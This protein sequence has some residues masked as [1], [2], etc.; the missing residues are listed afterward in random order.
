[1]RHLPISRD[2][3][4][5]VYRHVFSSKPKR[6]CSV[7]QLSIVL[8][9]SLAFAQ[10]ALGLSRTNLDL[11]YIHH[12]NPYALGC[13][14]PNYKTE[15]IPEVRVTGGGFEPP[16]R[17]DREVGIPLKTYNSVHRL[18]GILAPKQTSPWEDQPELRL[19]AAS[20]DLATV[21]GPV[22]MF[23]PIMVDS[24]LSQPDAYYHTRWY[25]HPLSYLD[26]V[27]GTLLPIGPPH[28]SLVTRSD[29][30][31]RAPVRRK[32][33]DGSA[34]DASPLEVTRG[35]VPWYTHFWGYRLGLV[36][37]ESNFNDANRGK[38]A[39][40]WPAFPSPANNFELAFLPPPWIEDDVV[41]Y[42]NQKDFPKQPDGQ[43]FYAVL[44]A[45]KA[46][47]DA[48]AS[49]RRTGKSFKSGGYVSVCRFYG[50]LNGGPN[51]HFYSADDKEC[52]ALKKVPVLSYEGQT[53]AVNM[54][55]PA[56]TASQALPG[57]L[58]DCPAKSKP[59]YRLY[60]N[61]SAPGK[62]YVSNH[63]YVT[64]RADVNAAV[65]QGWVDEG[66]VMCVPE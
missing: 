43:F 48:V 13:C 14:Y 25:A 3:V 47:L 51:T 38:L 46:A 55:M 64:D 31:V 32:A 30:T 52:A 5:G 40:G 19:Y 23:R 11:F 20:S 18:V 42:V 24:V 6:I 50:G 45:D 61:A 57:A 53:F 15:F 1:M 65:A 36:A 39:P 63:R 62:D 49:W 34:Y 60:N 22:S 26:D 58:R 2:R 54:P 44:A 66:H 59:L 37:N 17:P 41:E 28:T 35:G 29:Y 16:P 8:T 27:V 12:I 10:S 7:G 33:I 4:I 21:I 9:L 56:K